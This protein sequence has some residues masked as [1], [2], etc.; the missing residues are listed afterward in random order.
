[1]DISKTGLKRIVSA[2]R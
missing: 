1:M 2:C